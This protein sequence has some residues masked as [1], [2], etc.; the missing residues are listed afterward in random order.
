MRPPLATIWPEIALIKRRHGVWP[1]FSRSR[2][3]AWILDGALSLNGETV[4]P[5]T[6]VSAGQ[7][8]RL[9]AL[10]KEVEAPTAESIPLTVI[11]EDPDVLVIDKP[12]GLVVHPGAGNPSGTLQNA[13][14]A[15][16]PQLAELPRAGIV[17]RLD[18]D[19]TGLLVVA[20]SLPAHTRLVADLQKRRLRREYQAVCVGAMTGGGAVD[21]PI[22]RHPRDRLRM[23][24]HPKGKPARTRYRVIRR[25]PAHTHIQVEL[26][27]GRTHQIRVHM[28]Y[29]RHPLI[30]D[31]LYG[32][33]L[34]VPKGASD[35]LREVL[36][37]FRRQALHASRLRFEHPTGGG[38]MD[39]RSP[40]PDDFLQLL[41]VLE[42]G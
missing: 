31:P 16:D 38:P 30:G 19:T 28:A 20:R 10:P 27:T 13:L 39:L 8:L 29:I 21:E 36:R 34:K 15:H 37:A 5:R 9:D 25:F 1:E 23:A 7:L 17:H 4:P 40:I 2:L 12:A 35:A 32:G 18:K 3:K 11:H 24:I 26:E 22:G 42:G 6:K 41:V 14:L 33:R